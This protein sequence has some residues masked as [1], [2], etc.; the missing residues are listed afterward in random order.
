[1]ATKREEIK[2]FK[3][4]KKHFKDVSL[5]ITYSSWYEKP[6]YWAVSVDTDL[7]LCGDE[8]E[9]PMKA[10]LSLIEKGGKEL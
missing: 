1:M 10:A 4:L 9:D 7:G 3:L 6:K 2:A 8:D 5:S